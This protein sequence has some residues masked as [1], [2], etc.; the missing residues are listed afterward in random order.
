MKV[1]AQK[2]ISYHRTTLKRPKYS[3]TFVNIT[4][5][6]KRKDIDKEIY[7]VYIENE[8]LTDSNEKIES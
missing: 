1:K 3:K 6:L 5:L 7:N 2:L 4:E 8:I